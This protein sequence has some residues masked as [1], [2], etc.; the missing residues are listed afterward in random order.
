M[1]KHARK[2]QESLLPH[3]L[4]HDEELE[5]AVNRQYRLSQKDHWEDNGVLNDL[6]EWSLGP[7]RLLW[8]GGSSGNQDSWVTEF[9]A[10]LVCALQ[11]QTPNVLFAF[12][13]QR[14]NG[15]L[16]PITI[17]RKLL[18]QLLDV[19]PEIAYETP[20]VCSKG[21]FQKAVTFRQTWRI[22]EHLASRVTNLFIVIDRI[23]ECEAD[24]EADLVHVLLPTLIGWASRNDSARVIVTSV[25][26]PPEEVQDLDLYPSY[27]DTTKRALK[28]K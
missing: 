9:S 19:H 20:E 5:I 15:P 11:P 28:R 27:I 21:R 6:F 14:S 22:F 8:I 2:L 26:D 10:D 12:C 17:V 25:Y 18:I 13:D 7:D 1:V 16:T 24:E 4:A 3:D 23:E